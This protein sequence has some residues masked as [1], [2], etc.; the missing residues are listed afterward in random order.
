M[1]EARNMDWAAWYDGPKQPPICPTCGSAEGSLGTAGA[2]F[3]CQQCDGGRWTDDS[4]S[5]HREADQIILESPYGRERDVMEI[6][7]RN[8]DEITRQLDAADARAADARAQYAQL[9][10]SIER[11]LHWLEVVNRR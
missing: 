9:A 10:A 1:P 7:G 6:L 2:Y 11:R 3:M 4:R 8:L 5:D